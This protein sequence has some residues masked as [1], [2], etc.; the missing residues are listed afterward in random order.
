MQRFDGKTVLVTGGASGIGEATVGRLHD[1]GANVVIAD[2]SQ[3][4][5]DKVA[6]K[7][8]GGDRFL[9]V[10]TD[11]T[12]REQVER[13][14]EKATGR[15]GAIDALINSAGVRA[16][17]SI[18]DADVEYMRRVMAVNLEGAFHT[19]QVFAR[20][21]ID[22]GRGGAIVNLASAAG[23]LGVPNRLPY[24]SS[25]HAVVGLSRGTAME[26][27]PHGIR[28]NAIT[29]GMIRTPMTAS[30]FEDPANVER[31]RGDHP[32]G[33][34]GH[35]EDVAALAVFLASDDAAFMTG[36]VI[37]VD[38]GKSAGIPSR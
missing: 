25:K 17:G 16:V 23:V 6:E 5:A 31:I 36:T 22:A 7:F 29:P 21:A 33:R 3:D 30:M 9:A 4:A 1:E 13:L 26:L 34:E 27:A 14:F 19:S 35:P 24:T 2:L 15:F 20:L 37:P 18:L 38:G 12:D 8:G 28:V 32:L 10:A 11:V